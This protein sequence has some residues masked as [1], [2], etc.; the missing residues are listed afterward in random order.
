[1]NWEGV[2]KKETYSNACRGRNEAGVD[3]GSAVRLAG[4]VIGSLHDIVSSWVEA[5]DD[6]ISDGGD[7]RIWCVN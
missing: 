4:S 3:G 5:E 7:G 1:M 2:S 6:F